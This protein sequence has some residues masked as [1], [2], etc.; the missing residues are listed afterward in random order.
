MLGKV[1]ASLRCNDTSV[2]D[3][4]LAEYF[5]EAP[6]Q[7]LYV[8]INVYILLILYIYTVYIM[9]EDPLSGW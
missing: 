2:F 4:R 8:Y 9:Y 3:H 6:S 7:Y 1:S 5:C